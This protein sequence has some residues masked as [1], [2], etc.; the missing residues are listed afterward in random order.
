MDKALKKLAKQ[1]GAR[2]RQSSGNG[3]P[4]LLLPNGRFVVISSTGSYRHHKLR[5]V[6]ADILRSLQEYPNATDD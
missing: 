1:Y 2:I 6:E 4:R 3:H 5:K